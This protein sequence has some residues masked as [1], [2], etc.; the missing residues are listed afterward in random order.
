MKDTSDDKKIYATT[1]QDIREWFGIINHAVFL[2]KLR[3]NFTR[4]TIARQRG[5]WAHYTGHTGYDCANLSP[6]LQE[7]LDGVG[8]VSDLSISKKFPNLRGFINVL[9]HEMVHHYQF[10]CE[11][12][13]FEPTNISHGKSFWS[14]KNTF[15]KYGLNLQR[16]PKI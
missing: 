3:T 2:G 7:E 16:V 5:R 10:E 8:I 13:G 11:N 4:V 15:R 12:P 6:S 1:E 9:A 14:W